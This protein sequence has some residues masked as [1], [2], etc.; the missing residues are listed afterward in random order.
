MHIEMHA[1]D[2]EHRRWAPRRGSARER[3]ADE[4]RSCRAGV[5]RAH[6]T[7]GPAAVG[8]ACRRYPG[9]HRGPTA[10]PAAARGVILLDTSVWIGFFDDSAHAAAVTRA[11]EAGEVLTHSWIL[12]ELA[13]GELRKRRAQV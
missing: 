12:G 3:W 9:R 8:R 11:L 2:L 4:D 13:L 10:P 6:R 1:D 5:A 7:G